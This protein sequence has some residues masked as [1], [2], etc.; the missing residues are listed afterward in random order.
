M[1]FLRHPTKSISGILS[2]TWAL[3]RWPSVAVAL[4]ILAALV[5]SVAL[6]AVWR[7]VDNLESNT[8]DLTGH[9]LDLTKKVT[10]LQKAVGTQDPKG[11]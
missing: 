3:V 9:V 6:F 5:L 8:Q 11:E 4:A 2:V 1:I 10:G 7:K